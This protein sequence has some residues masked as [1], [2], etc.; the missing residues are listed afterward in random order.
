MIC[1]QYRLGLTVVVALVLVAM[2]LVAAAKIAGTYSCRGTNPNGRTYSGTTVITENG[3][4]YSLRWT[5]SGKTHS[6]TGI[7]TGGQLSASWGSPRGAYG[8]V[9]YVVKDDGRLVG[10]WIG[11]SGGNLGT[12]TLRPR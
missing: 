2:P 10:K 11:P 5:I 9:V 4:G 7:L 8:V 3:G 12:E 1:T 6:G